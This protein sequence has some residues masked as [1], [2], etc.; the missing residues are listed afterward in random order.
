M[1]TL[2]IGEVA[3]RSGFS[4][5]SLRYYEGIGLVL[6]A[7]RTAAGHR[8]Y[9]DAVLARLAFIARAK[10]LGCTLD[11]ITDLVAICEADECAPAQRRFHELVTAKIG[12]TQRRLAELARFAD[13]LRT[14]AAQLSTDPIDGPCGPGCACLGDAPHDEPAAPEPSIACTLT[15]GDAAERVEEWAALLV[16]A[17]SRTRADDGALRLTFGPDTPTDELM[18]L[19]AAEQRCCGFFAFAITLDPA[20][21]GLE[22]RAPDGAAS[23]VAAL[24]GAAA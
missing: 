2:T 12:Q 16:H 23:I 5:S 11:E 19:V 13:Q 14:A 6:P 15:A 3:E 18:R 8:V 20:G 4:A 17:T 21:L 7:S 1:G 9:D 22:V 24:F 10:Q